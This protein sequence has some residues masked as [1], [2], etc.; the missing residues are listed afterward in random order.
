MSLGDSI[1]ADFNE[2]FGSTMENLTLIMR[3]EMRE[4]IGIQVVYQ[5]AEVIRSLPG[6]PPR[7]EFGN[8]QNSQMIETTISQDRIEGILY[9]DNIIGAY[10]EH[11]TGTISPRPHYAP[12]AQRVDTLVEEMFGTTKG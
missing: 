4:L 12:Y 5:G 1:N 6:E 2:R 3:D 7:R 11:E 8:L 9:T 10:L